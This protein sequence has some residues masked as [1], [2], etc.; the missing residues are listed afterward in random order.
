MSWW[1]LMVLSIPKDYWNLRK[2]NRSNCTWLIL[3]FCTLN[4]ISIRGMELAFYSLVFNLSCKT[5]MEERLNLFSMVSLLRRLL[6][7][8]K[9]SYKPKRMHKALRLA[10]FIWLVTILVEILRE[11]MQLVGNLF[12]W[13][14]VFSSQRETS[15]FQIK[16]SI[17]RTMSLEWNKPLILFLIWKT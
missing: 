4:S 13:R 6:N 8:L 14:R 9:K 12:L 3:I 5:L 10:T 17:H 15:L 16:T 7:M 11:L 2:I 1:A